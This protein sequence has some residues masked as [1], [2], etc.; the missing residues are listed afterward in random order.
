MDIDLIL[1]PD[2]SPSEVKELG[3]L[4]E[5]YGIRT[6]WMSN[7]SSARD[8]FM[9]M[10]PVAEATRRLGIGVLVVSPWEMHPLKIANSLLTLNEFAGGRAQLVVSGGGEWCGVMGVGHERRVRAVRETTEIIRKA[11]S[12]KPLTYRGQLY[13]SFGYN[14][15]WARA[16]APTVYVGASKRQMM[17]MA[18]EVA[19]GAMM[20]DVTLHYIRDMVGIARERLGE[21]NQAGRPFRMSNFWAWHVKKDRSESL[22]EARRELILRGWLARYHVEPFMTAEECNL[23][24]THKNAFLKAYTDRSGEIA[25]VPEAV[26]NKLIENFCCAGDLSTLDRHVATLKQ[27]AAAGL[28]EIALRLHDDPQDGIRMIGER[29]LPALK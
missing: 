1:E 21:L 14:A 19:D 25:G 8:A 28:T 23:I 16:A 10:V 20:S 24:E 22:R 4:A 15:A 2:R 3:L 5:R 13:K 11:F 6:L 9:T 18:A 17:R 12:G 7:Y 26:V 29:V 27:F